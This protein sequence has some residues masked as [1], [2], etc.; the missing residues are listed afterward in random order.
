MT[1]YAAAPPPASRSTAPRSPAP[2]PRRAPRMAGMSS[3][4]LR[5][6][7]VSLHTSPLEEP[8]GADAGGLNVVVL[9]QSLAL[10]RLGHQADRFARR[11]HAG[12]PGVV[13]VAEGL[14][15]FHRDAGPA[16]ALAKSAMEQAIR[17]FRAALRAVLAA[18]SAGGWDLL[19]SHH[20]FSG[21]SALPIA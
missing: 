13:E 8:G 18:A 1:S 7:A 11:C 16:R 3:P 20:W 4:S 9:E 6:A 5:I 19:Q 2:S 17:P 21:C 15:Q 14:P 12:A 10:A